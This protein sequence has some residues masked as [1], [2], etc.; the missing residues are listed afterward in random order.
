ML[1]SFWIDHGDDRNVMPWDVRSYI[2]RL[3][4]SKVERYF[5][6]DDSLVG[7]GSESIILNLQESLKLTLTEFRKSLRLTKLVLTTHDQFTML[8]SFKDR[9]INCSVLTEK[10]ISN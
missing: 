7:V 1:C 3:R 6:K 5:C 9:N 4:F 2:G 8:S 10:A